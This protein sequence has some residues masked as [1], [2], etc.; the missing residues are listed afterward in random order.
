VPRH[1]CEPNPQSRPVPPDSTRAA[2]QRPPDGKPKDPR[3]CR[4]PRAK[5][6]LSILYGWLE[7]GAHY[8]TEDRT[9]DSVFEFDRPQVSDLHPTTKPVEL[10]ARMVA[11]SSRPRELI[12]DPFAGS[13]STILA[14]HQLGRIGY[15]CELDPGY[16]AVELERFS[17]LGQ[18]P[19]V[20]GQ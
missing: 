3:R 8:F 5:V 19:E 14:A 9:Q 16:V 15:G 1:V 11:N 2:V 18:K 20:A 4:R 7:N 17:L 10:I 6:A 12:Y 13:G